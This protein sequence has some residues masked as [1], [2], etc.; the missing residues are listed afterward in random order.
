MSPDLTA[1][2]IRSEHPWE[3]ARRLAFARWESEVRRASYGGSLPDGIGF[4]SAL[5]PPLDWSDPGPSRR[6]F[7]FSALPDGLGATYLV[8]VPARPRPPVDGSLVRLIRPVKAVLPT[9]EAAYGELLLD[10]Q[11]GIA[12]AGWEEIL[13]GEPPGAATTVVPQLSELWH[14][15]PLAVE[16]LLLPLVGS[17]PWH[18]RPAHVDLHLE[19]EGWS[20]E[21]HRGFLDGL[22][23]LVPPWVASARR[24][25][26]PSSRVLEL[27]SGARI[28]RPPIARG[29]PFG[30]HLRPITAPPS[31]RPPDHSVPRTVITYGRALTSEF[32]A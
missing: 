24:A 4:V 7:A 19:V 28:R 6:L 1:A 14:L 3:R 2:T 22:L 31:A 23:G 5:E 12:P 32:E 9:A 29:R 15:P 18:G 11:R 17:I 30:I 21:R 10:T 25:R 8:A 20:L 16:S 27:A 13:P 26:S